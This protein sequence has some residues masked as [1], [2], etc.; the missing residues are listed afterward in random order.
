MFLLLCHEKETERE[1]HFSRGYILG[2]MSWF[3][4]ICIKINE[5]TSQLP[6]Q[7]QIIVSAFM[8]VIKC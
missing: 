8:N 6:H 7:H 5:L 4:N 3:E 2:V 1:K